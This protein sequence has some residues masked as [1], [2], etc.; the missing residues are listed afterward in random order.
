MRRQYGKMGK[1]LNNVVTPDE[2]CEAYGADVFRLYEMSMG[3]LDVSRPWQT[4][5]VVGAQRFL[6]RLWRLVVDEQTGETVVTDGPP[7]PTIE[8]M[9]HH[10]I[11]GVRHDYEQLSYH[12]AIAKLITLTNQLVKSGGA[13]RRSVVEPLVLMT[14]PLAPHVCEELWERLGHS[15]SLA[16]GPFPTADPAFLRK[17]LISYPV[18]VRG[19]VRV[20]VEVPADA[21]QATVESAALT[22]D[23]VVSMLAGATPRK[24]VVVPGRMISIVL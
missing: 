2:M 6:Q 1:S 18:Q 5:D 12:T 17:E 11:D 15:T 20:R 10:T 19:K 13:A 21:D 24:V 7:E 16:H 8:R 23:R 14:A 22:D 3:P 9:L 4:R